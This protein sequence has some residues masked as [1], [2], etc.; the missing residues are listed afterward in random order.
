MF[1]F[2]KDLGVSSNWDIKNP[3]LFPRYLGWFLCVHG[4]GAENGTMARNSSRGSS[5]QKN[6][7]REA[8]V[9]GTIMKE[10]PKLYTL[11]ISFSYQIY[12]THNSIIVL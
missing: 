6:A 3:W 8:D 5:G 7:E 9:D 4:I 1:C 10:A 11:I 12:D 2:I